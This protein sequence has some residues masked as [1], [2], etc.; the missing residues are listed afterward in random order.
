MES[1]DAR[2]SGL[3]GEWVKLSCGMVD[4]TSPFEY[5]DGKVVSV[6]RKPDMNADGSG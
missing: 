5:N 1:N 4:D 6:R 3:A 2:G